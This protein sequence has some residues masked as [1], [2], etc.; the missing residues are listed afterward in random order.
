MHASISS[1]SRATGMPRLAALSSPIVRAVSIQ[2]RLMQ[3]GRISAS[4]PAHTRDLGPGGAR[5]T[6][7]HPEDDLLQLGLGGLVLDE[8]QKRVEG[9]EQR[10]ARQG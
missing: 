1:R 8:G 10:D 3:M 7:H 4:S 5:E 2:L 9:E 6:A